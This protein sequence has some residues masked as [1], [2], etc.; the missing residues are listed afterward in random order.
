MKRREMMIEMGTM[1]EEEEGL[2]LQ[3]MVYHGQELWELQVGIGREPPEILS[4]GT[5][6]RLWTVGAGKRARG[7]KCPVHGQLSGHRGRQLQSRQLAEL[8]PLVQKVLSML[9]DTT[10]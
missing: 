5:Q 1:E 2:Q 3:Q 10:H 9:S 7:R 6:T 4:L 8:I